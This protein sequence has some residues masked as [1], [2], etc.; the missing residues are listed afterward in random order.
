MGVLEFEGVRDEVP[1]AIAKLSM[2]LDPR[3]YDL[4][5]MGPGEDVT[6]NKLFLTNVH[7]MY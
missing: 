4:S 2:N 7:A 1:N 5:G 6:G 3:N